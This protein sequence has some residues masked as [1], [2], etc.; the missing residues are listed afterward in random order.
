VLNLN[1]VDTFL[2]SLIAIPHVDKVEENK[3]GNKADKKGKPSSWTNSRDSE[4]DNYSS[5][6]IW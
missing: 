6:S 3:A 5:V 2:R 4:S 1:K